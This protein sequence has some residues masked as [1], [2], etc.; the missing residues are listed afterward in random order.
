MGIIDR[1][2]Y[3]NRVEFRE[4]AKRR[5]AKEIGAL[6]KAGKISPAGE[7]AAFDKAFK[8]HL[9]LVRFDFENAKRQARKRQ[10][11]AKAVAK[12]AIKREKKAKAAM[13]SV[14]PKK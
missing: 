1:I 13:A 6:R 14:R 3:K 2:L 5:A 9:P 4:E 12:Q 7:S 8:K 10:Q 11:A